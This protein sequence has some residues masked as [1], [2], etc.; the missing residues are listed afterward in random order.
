MRTTPNV[1]D[2]VLDPAPIGTRLDPTTGLVVFDVPDDAPKIGSEDVQR[3]LDEEPR[4][5]AKRFRKR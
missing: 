2:D 5:D 3:A 1:D 4:E